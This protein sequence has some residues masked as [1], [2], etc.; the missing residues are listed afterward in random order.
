MI[1]GPDLVVRNGEVVTVPEA[2]SSMDQSIRGY[3]TMLTRHP[4]ETRELADTIIK[5]TYRTLM[6]RGL[7]GCFIY[8]TDPETNEYFRKRLAA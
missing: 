6:T 1:I 3:R 8:C 2:R 7:K 4:D 5:N